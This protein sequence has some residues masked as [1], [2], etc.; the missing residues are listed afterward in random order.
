MARAA[1]MKA[2]PLWLLE[3]ALVTT[4]SAFFIQGHIR[5]K[6]EAQEKRLFFRWAP[7]SIW[8]TPPI[9]FKPA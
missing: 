5:Y 7:T 2:Q 4:F 1:S 8:G 6:D 9:L 3:S